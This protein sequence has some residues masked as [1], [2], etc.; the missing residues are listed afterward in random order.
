ME[1]KLYG[2]MLGGIMTSATALSVSDKQNG[3]G[4]NQCGVVSVPWTGQQCQSSQ[5][6]TQCVWLI[7]AG[8]NIGESEDRTSE[9][10]GE[11]SGL[12][13]PSKD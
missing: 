1:R 8:F 5:R 10:R 11:A 7:S 9:D 6:R 2:H 3:H 4:A 12:L 13:R